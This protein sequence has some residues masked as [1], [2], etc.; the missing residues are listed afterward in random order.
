MTLNLSE[1]CVFKVGETYRTRGGQEARIYATD[2][3]HTFPIHGAFFALDLGWHHKD[4]RRDGAYRVDGE[5]HEFDLMP[6]KRKVWI[7]VW[8]DP[9]CATIYTR[10]CDNIDHAKRIANKD[11]RICIKIFDPVDV[12]P[13]Q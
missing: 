13:P 9:G 1:P 11:S 5:E 3:F 10:A 12:E 4:W 2:G 7:A 8:R 6:S